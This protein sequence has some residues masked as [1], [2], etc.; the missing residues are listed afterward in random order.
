MSKLSTYCIIAQYSRLVSWIALC[1]IF[2]SE[3][4]GCDDELLGLGEEGETVKR[5]CEDGKVGEEVYKCIG[6]IWTKLEDNCVLE[7]IKN[8]EEES[9]VMFYVNVEINVLFKTQKHK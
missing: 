8:L 1:R 5:P 9:Q 7:E 2:I 3:N 4:T 6:D